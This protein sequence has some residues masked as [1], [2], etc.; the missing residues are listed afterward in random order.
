MST[1]DIT[2]ESSTCP[3]CGAEIRVD[4]QFCYNCGGRL[5]KTHSNGN[6]PAEF[7]MKP[8]P[9]L[10]TARDVKRRER[11]FQRKVKEV[12]WEPAAEGET[13]PLLIV[14]AIVSIFTILVIVFVF[15]FR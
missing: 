14:T 4:S 8:A 9:G 7:Q 15:Y 6:L 11:T 10:R 13:T 3:K 2:V 5:D 1:S 12:V